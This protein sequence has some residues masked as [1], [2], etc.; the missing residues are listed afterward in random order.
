MGNLILA[1][2]T[3]PSG[4]W[5]IIL[6]WIQ[7]GVANYAWTIILFTLLVKVCLSPLDFFIKWSTKKSTL[8][9]QK[10]APQIAKLQKKYANNNQALQLQTQALYKK[11]G[12]NIGASCVIMLINLVVTLLVF[13]SIF[14]S[15]KEVSAY[16]SIKQ[17][18]AL[19]N[20]YTT[21]Y[22]QIYDEEFTKRVNELFA[23]D[24]LGTYDP[25]FDYNENPD[26]NA[27]AIENI[28]EAQTY[29]T[30]QAGSSNAVKEAV[31]GTWNQEKESWAWITNIWVTDGK[32]NA[33]PTYSGLKNLATSAKGLFGSNVNNEYVDVVNSIDE[34]HYNT[35]TSI[36]QENLSGWNGYYILAILAGVVTFLSTYLTE[37]S[38]KLKRKK[39][40]QQEV[41]KK[42]QFIKTPES[43]KTSNSAPQ[44]NGTM[45][46]MKIIMP[47]MMVIFVLS[48]SAAFGIYVVTQSLISIGLGAI[49]NLIVNKITYKKQLEVL[50][51]LD[52]IEGKKKFKYN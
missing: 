43:E 23:E 12:Y 14:T 5:V 17:Y 6:N 30:Q 35:V 40:P 46:W 3:A 19:D 29:A 8:V 39:Q 45:K 37:L 9:Q 44:V 10:C 20:A 48:S 7:S 28:S 26:D 49:I 16:Q 22:S 1:E 47:I 2:L 13:L 32:A 41:V 31:I 52:K 50:E 25:T 34:G 36:V 24:N 38:S 21:T 4:L 42:N 18:Q 27:L 51:Y 33:L 15:L 11:E